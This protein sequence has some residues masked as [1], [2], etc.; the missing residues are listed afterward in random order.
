MF[1]F[2]DNGFKEIGPASKGKSHIAK[3]EYR[4]GITAVFQ[5]MNRFLKPKAKVFVV[6]NDRD[7]IYPE[8]ASACG[9][10]IEK[11]FHRPVLMRTERDNTNFSESIY[12]FIKEN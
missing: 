1:G 7:N 3:E 12:Y 10:K 6:V 4:K 8:I 9:Y 11:I 2:Y 5:N